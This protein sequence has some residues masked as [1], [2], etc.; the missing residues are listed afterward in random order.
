MVYEIQ[1]YVNFDIKENNWLYQMNVLKLLYLP[2]D[3]V[4]EIM[5]FMCLNKFALCS[6]H[7]WFNTYNLKFSY[8]LDNRYY[9]FLLRNDYGFIFDTYLKINFPKFLIKH[10]TIYQ[11]KVFPRKIELVRYLTCFVF[12]SPKCKKIVEDYMK[13]HKLVFKKIRVKLNTWTN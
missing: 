4:G 10:K 8:N 11:N 3:I 9:R 13:R 6:K 1:N 7:H 12:K 5:S 2:E